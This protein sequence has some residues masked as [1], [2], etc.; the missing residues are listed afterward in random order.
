MPA[1]IGLF[2]IESSWI[3]GLIWLLAS[4]VAI[5]LLLAMVLRRREYLTETLRE[6][7]RKQ[8]QR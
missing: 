1:W 5:R 4:L 3:D 8:Q 2:G 6:Y 7:V